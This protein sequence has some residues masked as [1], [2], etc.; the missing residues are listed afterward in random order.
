GHVVC[1][2]ISGGWVNLVAALPD[3]LSD[4]PAAFAGWHEDVG[5]LLAAAGPTTSWPLYDRAPLARWCTDRVAL[6]GDAAHPLLP[7]GAQGANQAIEDAAALA[8]CL[9]DCG[10]ADVSDALRRYESVRVPR[11]AR[12]SE[13]VQDNADNHHLPDGAR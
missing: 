8:A 9:R 13:M 7:F 5:N 4:L 12:V 11:L 3:P 1:Y 10:P 6:V 2:P